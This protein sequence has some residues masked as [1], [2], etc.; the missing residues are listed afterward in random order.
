MA[1]W[2]RDV[3]LLM[4]QRPLTAEEGGGYV[5]YGQSIN[6]VVDEDTSK[7]ASY[8]QTRLSALQHLMSSCARVRSPGSSARMCTCLASSSDRWPTTPSTLASPTSSRVRAW[9]DLFALP[10]PAAHPLTPRDDTI[11]SVDGAGW[12][13]SSITNLAYTYQPLGIIGLRKLLTGSPQP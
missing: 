9:L 7:Y 10:F 11:Q 5:L 6:G 3:A 1:V 12:L 13:P 4:G 2:P 8:L